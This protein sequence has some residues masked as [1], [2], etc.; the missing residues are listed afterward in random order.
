METRLETEGGDLVGT[1]TL[2]P[3]HMPPK[4]VQWGG[5]TFTFY[6]WNYSREPASAIY[7]ECVVWCITSQ[8]QRELTEKELAANATKITGED[9]A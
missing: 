7:R 2:P 4:V 8:M 6:R 9:G 3:F 5:R 1:F